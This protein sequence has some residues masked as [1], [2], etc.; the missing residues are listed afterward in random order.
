MGSHIKIGDGETLAVAPSGVA[1][2]RLVGRC[3]PLRW[4]Q[5]TARVQDEEFVCEMVAKA[6]V[7]GEG[8]REDA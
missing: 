5:R 6:P 3:A 8:C 7:V 4:G 1:R 2:K